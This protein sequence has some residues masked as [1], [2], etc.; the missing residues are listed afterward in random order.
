MKLDVGWVERTRVRVPLGLTVTQ[1][2]TLEEVVDHPNLGHKKA[3]IR[4]FS[5]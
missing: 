3:L 2:C 4:A 5:T 1:P